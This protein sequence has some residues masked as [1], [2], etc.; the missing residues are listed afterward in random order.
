VTGGEATINC[1]VEEKEPIHDVNVVMEI[2]GVH[3]EYILTIS[4][5]ETAWLAAVKVLT[6]GVIWAQCIWTRC[7]FRKRVESFLQEIN[8]MLYSKQKKL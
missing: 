8:S 7:S 6:P 2:F 1:A 3:D 5:I 4:D